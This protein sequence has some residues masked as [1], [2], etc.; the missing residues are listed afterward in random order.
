MRV[1]RFSPNPTDYYVV[2]IKDAVLDHFVFLSLFI[3]EHSVNIT[4]LKNSLL[5]KRNLKDLLNYLCISVFVCMDCFLVDEPSP[6][7]FAFNC[8]LFGATEPDSRSGSRHYLRHRHLRYYI[9][10]PL[11]RLR[12][13]R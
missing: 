11:V 13:N 10:Y 7:R 8:L 4:L 9:P 5:V 6:P 3:T 12:L 1:I 2:I